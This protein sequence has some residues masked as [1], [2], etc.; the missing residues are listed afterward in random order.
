MQHKLS[1]LDLLVIS[2]DSNILLPFSSCRG[3]ILVVYL[4]SDDIFV[5]DNDLNLIFFFRSL[6]FH[7]FVAKCLTKEPRLRP[8]ASEMLKVCLILLFLMKFSDYEE[9]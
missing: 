7:D 2:S 6:Y 3:H 9:S 4:F 8:T 5:H 1:R